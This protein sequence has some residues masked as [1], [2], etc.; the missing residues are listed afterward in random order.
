MRTIP[1]TDKTAAT[2]RTRTSTP[3]QL[4]SA[5]SAEEDER[6]SLFDATNE[7]ADLG[8]GDT[9]AE[10]R[11]A[12]RRLHHPERQEPGFDADRRRSPVVNGI[13]EQ[14]EL[15]T[16]R[17]LTACLDGFYGALGRLPAA[18]ALHVLVGVD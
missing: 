17:L 3:P 6:Y 4:L 8:E 16:E 2:I 7:S 1:R 18:S 11:R 13:E 10:R 9:A 12:L 15:V 5:R 14:L